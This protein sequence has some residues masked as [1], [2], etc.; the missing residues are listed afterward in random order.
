MKIVVSPAKS[1]DLETP[2]PTN[3]FTNPSFLKHSKELIDALQKKSPKQLS[4]LMSISDALAALN[5]QRN[6]EWNLPFLPENARPA[7]YTFKGEVY[8]GLD[9]FTIPKEKWGQLEDKLRILSGLY[10]LLKPFD[11]IQPYRLEMGTRLQMGQSNNLYQFWGHSLTDALN[12]EMQETD[13]LVNLASTE[14]FK[15]LKSNS[16]KATVVTPHFKDYKNGK[17]KVISFFAKKARGLMVRYIIDQD[18]Q[19]V[20]GLKGFDAAGYE[21]SEA[22]SSET[23]LVFVR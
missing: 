1:L 10:G 7:V 9:A 14:Y 8:Q 2:I 13:V 18:L 21:F 22:L 4:E 23:D 6:Q 17:L 5:W 12:A 16:L 3:H 19:H 20:E 15:V 11:L